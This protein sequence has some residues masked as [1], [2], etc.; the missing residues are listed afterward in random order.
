MA[1]AGDREGPLRDEVDDLADQLD[2]ETTAA[3]DAMLEQIK[4]ILDGAETLTEAARRIEDIYPG[5]RPDE[6]AGKIAQALTTADLSGRHE[7]L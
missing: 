5:L 4:E 7:A 2:D 3:M 1:A 6:L